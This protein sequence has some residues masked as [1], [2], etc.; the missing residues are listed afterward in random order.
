MACCREHVAT[1][2]SALHGNHLRRDLNDLAGERIKPPRVGASVGGE[3]ARRPSIHRYWA[4][5]TVPD[6]VLGQQWMK[7]IDT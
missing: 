2:Q 4:T 6:A 3:W 7:D 5:A 1:L